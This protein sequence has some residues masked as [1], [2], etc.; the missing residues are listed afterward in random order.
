LRIFLFAPLP[1]ERVRLV[2]K[3][4]DVGAR[5]FGEDVGENLLR[6]ANVLG[7][8]RTDID[9][10]QVALQASGD[11]LRCK[12]FAGAWRSRKQAAHT[13]RR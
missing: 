5:S 10:V 6:F 4:T 9:D 3:E 1:E 12:R 7:D 13:A 8:D 2:E 11:C